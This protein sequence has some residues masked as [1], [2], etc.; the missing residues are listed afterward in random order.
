MTVTTRTKAEK[1]AAQLRS[2]LQVVQAEL[3]VVKDLKTDV[4]ELKGL[5]KS[6]LLDADKRKAEE[7]S[8]TE[9]GV[10]A[11]P[12]LPHTTDASSS[13]VV[14]ELVDTP[15]SSDII[16]PHTTIPPHPPKLS[17]LPPKPIPHHAP[18]PLPHSPQ[19]SLPNYNY[20]YSEYQ[21]G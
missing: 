17:P 8:T 19:Q 12:P 21:Q 6:F 2:E 7:I 14:I 13:V 16:P 18:Q 11:N 3:A 20:S 15:P 1:E 9:Q 5:L 10:P 4:D